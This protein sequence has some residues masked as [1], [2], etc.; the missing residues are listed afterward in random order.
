MVLLLQVAM[1]LMMS[2][3]LPQLLVIMLLLTLVHP[4]SGVTL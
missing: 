3:L 4:K 2:Q 1:T